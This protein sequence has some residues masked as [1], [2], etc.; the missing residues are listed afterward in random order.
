MVAGH[1]NQFN[2]LQY[3]AAFVGFDDFQF[4]AGGLLLALNTFGTELLGLLCLPWLLRPAPPSHAAWALHVLMA[5]S[6]LR[7]LLTAVCVTVQRRHLMVWAIFAPKLIFDAA[8]HLVTAATATGLMLLLEEAGQ[9][10]AG[11]Q[12]QHQQQ[13]HKQRVD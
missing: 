11:P 12:Q 8:L 9:R 7:T 5:C 4:E 6:G 2:R 10:R 1:H 13:Q 3:S